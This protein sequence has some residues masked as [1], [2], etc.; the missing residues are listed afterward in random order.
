M[1]KKAHQKNEHI[2][3]NA[4]IKGVSETKSC[5]WRGEFYKIMG[6]TRKVRLGQGARLVAVSYVD[7]LDFTV[8]LVFP[9][10]RLVDLA[11][12]IERETIN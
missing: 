5:D 10:G 2:V 1:L 4:V 11:G 8:K 6:I 12:A 9:D 7:P 3:K